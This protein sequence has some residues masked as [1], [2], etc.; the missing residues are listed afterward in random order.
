MVKLIAI[1][2][3]M[4]VLSVL[5]QAQNREARSLSST[6]GSVASYKVVD[7]MPSFWQ[8]WEKA[9]TLDET[10]KVR[11]FREMVLQPN[12]EVFE[13]FTG[14]ASDERILRYFANVQPHIPGMQ[15]LYQRLKMG[16]PRY[17]QIFKKHFPD[18]N[19]NGE[20]YLMPNLLGGWDAGGGS[21]GKRPVIILGV[22]SILKLR[23]EGFNLA[24]LFEHELFHLYHNQLHPEWNNKSRA[25]GE[26]PLYWLLWTEGLATHVSKALNPKASADDILL[27]DELIRETEK[28]MPRLAR[29]LR[30][31]LDSTATDAFM[32]FLSG[33]PKRTDI[34]ARCGY[35]IGMLVARE[36]GKKLSLGRLARLEGA[37]LRGEIEKAL[38]KLEA[39]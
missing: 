15:R 31:N 18:V 17:G 21:L 20:I 6:A 1:V 28:Q 5:N 23:P 32:N 39:R 4:N 3:V 27:T 22:D 2:L 35:Y 11:L 36:M 14:T 10:A 30:E 25:K 13:G 38:I 8:F 26:I 9:Q 33:N 12:K 24:T 29:A 19:G 7:I 34:P 37:P 16:L